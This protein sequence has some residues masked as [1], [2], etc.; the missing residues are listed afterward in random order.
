MYETWVLHYDPE[1]KNAIMMW[2][3]T[4]QSITCQNKKLNI[5]RKWNAVFWD[6][7]SLMSNSNVVNEQYYADIYRK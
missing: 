2:G 1:S 4:G 6:M 3:N 5:C 7:K